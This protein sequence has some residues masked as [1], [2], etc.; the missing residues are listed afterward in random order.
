MTTDLLDILLGGATEEVAPAPPAAP[1]KPPVRLHFYRCA[2]CLSI[3][4]SADALQYRHARGYLVP[5]GKCGACD[6]PLEYLGRTERDRLIKEH[7]ACPCDDRCT[8]ARG[9]N[10]S[11]KC[12]GQNHGSNMTVTVRTDEGGIPVAMIDPAARLKANEYRAAK[13]EFWDVW[14]PRYRAITD[15]KQR[16]EWIEAFSVYVDGQCLARA[17]HKAC[18]LRTH[19]GRNR[20]LN[21]LTEEIRRRREVAA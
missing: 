15:K 10:C 2:D 4:T 7:E 19:A 6:G 8:S 21:A 3:C 11:C 14:N 18:D 17:F 5:G 13:K 16:G 12:G 1:P 20:K 9:P